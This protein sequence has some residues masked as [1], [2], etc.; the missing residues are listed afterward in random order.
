[1]VRL[2][3][4]FE[5]RYPKVKLDLAYVTARQTHNQME[6]HSVVAEW[7]GEDRLVV[8]EPTQHVTGN[9]AGLARLFGLK[10]ENVR[11]RSA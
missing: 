8:D 1:M 7:E 5:H 6:P 3:T 9:R 10:P 2:A 11:V 4:A